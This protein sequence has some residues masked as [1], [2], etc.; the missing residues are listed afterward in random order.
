MRRA[1]LVLGS[2]AALVFPVAS[3]AQVPGQDSVSLNGIATTGNFSVSTLTA[4]SGPSG[5]NPSG[6]VAFTVFGLVVAR[7]ARSHVSR[8]MG[9]RPP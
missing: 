9:T 6:Q 7:P 8:S 5:E 1:L 4:T 2:R 3:F